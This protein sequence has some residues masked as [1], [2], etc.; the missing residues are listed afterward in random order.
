MK[1]KKLL[2]KYIKYLIFL[3]D[4]YDITGI[5][6]TGFSSDIGYCETFTKEEQ[7]KLEEI[8]NRNYEKRI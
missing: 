2:E 3:E 6:T 4:E 1:Y 5:P 8:K 7:K